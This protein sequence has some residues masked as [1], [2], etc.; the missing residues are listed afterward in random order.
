MSTRKK[1]LLLIL[2][3]SLIF[4]A[5]IIIKNHIENTQ[6][7]EAILKKEGPRVEKYFKYNFKNIDKVT[8][9]SLDKN[10]MGGF[11][12]DGYVNDDPKWGFGALIGEQFEGDMVYSN[13]FEP[14]KK[15]ADGVRILKPIEDIE[16]EEKANQ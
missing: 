15:D 6:L 10:P 12:M 8:I 13:K 5:G 3:V 16:K 11:I 1:S 2:L 9:E 14:K 7:E 4:V